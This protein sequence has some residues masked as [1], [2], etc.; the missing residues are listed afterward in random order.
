MAVEAPLRLLIVDDHAV[1]REG[2]ARALTA[3][4]SDSII[5]H[6]T[7]LAE[8]QS[9]LAAESFD[10]AIVDIHL[11]DNS[12]LELVLW[13]R[14]N[15]LTMGVIVFSM[16]NHPEYIL[17]AMDNGASGFLDKSAPIS[18]LMTMI[19][20]VARSPLIFQCKDLQRAL[21]YRRSKTT[22]TAREVEILQLLPTGKTYTELAET[23][24][25]SE[26]TLKTHLQSIYRK[27]TARN[28][29]EA[30]N[31]ARQLGILPP[32]DPNSTQK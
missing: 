17:A 16:N 24:F 2:V 23:L 31:E 12:G 9:R 1:V 5:A 20:T 29:L 13:I 3:N 10:V 25:I 4:K 6:A 28:R 15:S 30:I 26:S 11:A 7:T 14:E 27:L 22:L 18:E 32:I 19:E 21:A 8:A